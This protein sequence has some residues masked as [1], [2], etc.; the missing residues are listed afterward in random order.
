MILLYIT[1]TVFY[2]PRAR[3]RAGAP[4]TGGPTPAPLP[5]SDASRAPENHSVALLRYSTVK[6]YVSKFASSSVCACLLREVFA[7]S[8]V[9]ALSVPAGAASKLEFVSR[10]RWVARL[11]RCVHISASSDTT[12]PPISRSI[13]LAWRTF[14]HLCLTTRKMTRGS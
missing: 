9:P 2:K 13:L 6:P 10:T 7:T 1:R 4:P 12:P 5:A 3:R 14:A 11:C 8:V